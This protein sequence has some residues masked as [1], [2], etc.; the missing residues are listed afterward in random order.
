MFFF[1]ANI[2]SY[3]F[4]IKHNDSELFLASKHEGKLI[5]LY[6]GGQD[7]ADL[8]IEHEYIKKFPYKRISLEETIDSTL[9]FDKNKREFVISGFTGKNEQKFQFFPIDLA[10]NLFLLANEDRCV[11]YNGNTGK[12]IKIE[13]E[14]K[15]KGQI[16][17]LLYTEQDKMRKLRATKYP[18]PKKQ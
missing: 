8:F 9:S 6:L 14:K 5:N 2:L 3:N 17:K 13:C 7:E 1:I 10:N 12:L 15:R 18:K 4:Y 11:E 16:F